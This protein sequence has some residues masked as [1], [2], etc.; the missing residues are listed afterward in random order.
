MVLIW[1]I[2]IPVSALITMVKVR[3]ILNTWDVQKYLLMLYQGLKT[4]KFYWELV[5]TVRKSLL[6]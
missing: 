3:K 6:L 5:N 1:G 2:G 4:D